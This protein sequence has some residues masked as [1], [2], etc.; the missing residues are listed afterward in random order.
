MGIEGWPWSV[1][2]G[3]PEGVPLTLRDVI[4][5]PVR[6]VAH[7][8]AH[9]MEFIAG[10]VTFMLDANGLVSEVQVESNSDNEK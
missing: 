7:G 8:S 6:I 5:R 10:R 1:N 4:G 3:I 9:T 2:E